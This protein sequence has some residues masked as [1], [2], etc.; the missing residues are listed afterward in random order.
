MYI[1]ETC[2]NCKVFIFCDLGVMGDVHMF[3]MWLVESALNDVIVA[4]FGTV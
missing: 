1:F 3:W 2:C 4:N